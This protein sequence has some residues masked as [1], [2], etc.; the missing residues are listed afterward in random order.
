MK[1]TILTAAL[2]L[3]SIIA[4]AQQV[5]GTSA[6]PAF[7][8]DSGRY[9][10][11]GAGRG[12]SEEESLRLAKSEALGRIFRETGKDEL[13]SEM[14]VSS[15][16]EAI[17]IESSSSERNSDG[18]FSAKAKISVDRNAT[19]LLEQSY[20]SAAAAL[21]DKAEKLLASA[22]RKID[23][24]KEAEAELRLP[25]AFVLYR[26]G[27]GE[28]QQAVDSMKPLGDNSLL[29]ERG[30][31]LASLRRMAASLAVRADEGLSR[32]D[33]A[34][35]KTVS[36]SQAD[37]AGMTLELIEAEFAELS[38]S[39]EKRRAASP[40]YDL[41]AGE[42]ESIRD[43]LDSAMEKGRLIVERLG[44]VSA[45]VPESRT[46]L[47][48]KAAFLRTDAEDLVKSVR[49]MKQAAEEELRYP[50]LA[51]QEDARKSKERREAIAWVFLHKPYEYL[52]LRYELPV[53]YDPDKG[54][55]DLPALNFKLSLEGSFKPGVWLR[56]SLEHK[57]T[58]YGA[59]N[60]RVLRQEA[61]IGL[62]GDTLWG[63]GFAW[64]WIRDLSSHGTD[65]DTV[66]HYAVKLHYG[67]ID[68]ER[69]RP[70]IVA[71][72]TYQIPRY[73]D[74]FIPAYHVNCGVDVRIK[75]E[76]YVFVE[77]SF[78]SKAVQTGTG[79]EPESLRG[80]LAHVVEWKIGVAF[81]L[82]SPFA[83]GISYRGGRIAPIDVE[84]NAGTYRRLPDGWSLFIEYAL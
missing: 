79:S 74:E 34:E 82:P 52:T 9:R 39:V 58:E 23:R 77:G 55:D 26:Q 17:R 13:F 72:L 41:P 54:W 8:E 56:T 12:A 14:F 10:A 46:F 68:R 35:K 18:S 66:D 80:N 36:A 57:E 70:F 63:I 45:S 6:E 50:R 47:K 38:K 1:R 29:S 27:R 3:L 2:A 51:R 19:M 4:S 84:G 15:W 78:A 71:S 62:F 67:K 60:L 30:T 64:D 44:A 21:L 16:P 22:E 73:T 69:Y 20:R 31:N 40:F 48:Q 59:L 65:L 25:D 33:V 83:W 42:L 43:E 37:E 61:S 53:L 28:G 7:S 11:A 75:A 32:I 76:D 24:A 49:G 81:R 5:A